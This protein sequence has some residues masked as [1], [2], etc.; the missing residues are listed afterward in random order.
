MLWHYRGAVPC[1]WAY[2]AGLADDTNLHGSDADLKEYEGWEAEEKAR[3]DALI[4]RLSI[5][6]GGA[7]SGPRCSQTARSHGHCNGY[8]NLRTASHYP[9]FPYECAS[10]ETATPDKPDAQRAAYALL[11][12]KYRAQVTSDPLP[13]D[14]PLT[15]DLFGVLIAWIAITLTRVVS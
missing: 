9:C 8:R 10:V 7:V 11:L 5:S 13:A 2:P 14:R 12:P 3:N 4:H 1:S 6:R 15:A